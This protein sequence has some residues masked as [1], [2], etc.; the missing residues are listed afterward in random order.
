MRRR[1]FIAGAIFSPWAFGAAWAQGRAWRHP[2][3]DQALALLRAARWRQLSA[4]VSALAPQRAHILLC[5][6]GAEAPLNLHLS[7]AGSVPMGATIAAAV[8]VDWAWR[9]RGT[10]LGSTVSPEGL[11]GFVDHLNTAKALVETAIADDSD[12][13]IAR[14]IGFKV[15]MGLSEREALARGFQGYLLA[16]R[17]PVAGFAAFANALSRKWLGTEE[18]ALAFAREACPLDLPASA[19][20]IPDVH[21]TAWQSRAI[22]DAAA[23]GDFPGYLAEPAVRAEIIA[24]NASYNSVGPDPDPFANWYANSWFSFAL[25][26]LGELDL[27]RGHFQSMGAYLGAPWADLPDAGRTIQSLRHRLGLESL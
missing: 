27:A 15:H 19:G 16:A 11:R 22:S 10:G 24:A 4:L 26:A 18:A 9:Y 17:R 25:T 5:D 6:L 2:E 20:L 13:G 14:A 23:G 8:H 12:D 3:L 7:A 1:L 21:F